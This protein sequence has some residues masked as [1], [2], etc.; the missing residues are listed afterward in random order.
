MIS[1]KEWMITREMLSPVP[2]PSVTNM[3]PEVG[4]KLKHLT[5]FQT[6]KAKLPKW[7]RVLKQGSKDGDW[8]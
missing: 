3:S 6:G 5:A 4:G 2:F 8:K 1:F 7:R